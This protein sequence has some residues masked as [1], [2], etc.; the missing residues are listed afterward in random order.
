MIATISTSSGKQVAK[1]SDNIATDF[2]SNGQST[3]NLHANNKANQLPQTGIENDKTTA[4]AGI[5]LAS[6]GIAV[7]LGTS[8]KKRRD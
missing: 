3:D 5:L 4:L 2:V 7:A 8:R 1:N 6:M